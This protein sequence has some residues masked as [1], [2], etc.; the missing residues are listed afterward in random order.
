MRKNLKKYNKKT[1][2]LLV[3][4]SLL[5][6]F[7]FNDLAFSKDGKNLDNIEKTFENSILIDSS[8]YDS[9]TL[10]VHILD[11]HGDAEAQK[12]ISGIIDFYDKQKPIEKI[13]AEGAPLGKVSLNLFKGIDEKFKK[14]ILD[15]MLSEMQIG[16]CEYY[17]SYNNRD[18]LFGIE[19]NELYNKNLK[20]IQDMLALNR[21]NEGFLNSLSSKV[22][23][24]K[25][26][27]LS[28]SLLNIEKAIEENTSN[29]HSKIKSFFSKDPD[30]DETAYESF[31]TYLYLKEESGKI[32]YKSAIKE[33]SALNKYLST[34]LSYK[35]YMQASSLL[36]ESG[37]RASIGKA[38]TIIAANAPEAGKKF[39]EIMTALR[40][41]YISQNMNTYDVYMQRQALKK[42]IADKYASEEEKEILYLADMVESVKQIYSL[43]ITRNDLLDFINARKQLRGISSKYLDIAESNTLVYLAENK[44]TDLIYSINLQRDMVFFNAVKNTIE[45]Q[46]GKTAP[47]ARPEEISGIKDF[48]RVF[49]VVTGGFHLEFTDFLRKNK[50]SYLNI[51]PKLEKDADRKQYI[52]T[53]NLPGKL[54]SKNITFEYCAFAPPLLNAVNNNENAS[55]KGIIIKN[56]VKAWLSSAEEAGLSKED[57]YADIYNWL[58]ENGVGEDALKDIKELSFL[59]DMHRSG[60]AAAENFEKEEEPAAAGEDIVRQRQD[61]DSPDAAVSAQSAG[62]EI[63]AADNAAEDLIK[64]DTVTKNEAVLEKSESSEETSVF[65]KIKKKLGLDFQHWRF[66]SVAAANSVFKA[67]KSYREFADIVKNAKKVSA[68]EFEV[69][70]GETGFYI[71]G[72]DGFTISVDEAVDV[73]EKFAKKKKRT[74]IILRLDEN[75]GRD[76]DKILA[77]TLKRKNKFVIISNDK[78][79]VKSVDSSSYKNVETAYLMPSGLSAVEALELIKEMTSA[80]VFSIRV[81]KS[82]FDS[83]GAYLFS[84]YRGKYLNLYIQDGKVDE[85]YGDFIFEGRGKSLLISSEPAVH[86]QQKK[87]SLAAYRNIAATPVIQLVIGFEFFASFSM[88]YL[89]GKGY[90]LSFLSTMFAFCGILNIIGSLVSSYASKFFGKRNVLMVN[91]LLHCAGDALLLV[92]GWSPVLLGFALGVPAM[93][94]AGIATLLIPFLHSSLKAVGKED[95]FES[96]YGKTRSIFWIG[97]ALSSIFGSWLAQAV[98][99]AFVIAL[100]S[101]IITVFSVYSIITTGTIED[102]DKQEMTDEEK[103]FSH[104]KEGKKI[105]Q[106]IKTVFTTKGLN[107]T[108]IINFIVDSV[109]FVLLALGVQPML[110]ESGLSLSLLGLVA[111]SANIMQSVASKYANKIS[112]IVNSTLKRTLYFAS[113]TA[114]AAGFIVFNNPLLL[115]AFYILANFWQGASSIIEPAKVEEKLPDDITPY[116]F[117]AKTIINSALAAA[118]QLILAS[119]FKVFSVDIIL[120]AVIGVITVAS[121]VLGS[122]FKDGHKKDKGI[123]EVLSDTQYTRQLLSAA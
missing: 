81:D 30:F 117:S 14:D 113:L 11:S 45:N 61:G 35:D 73:V 24:L 108:V 74:E 18:I 49:V 79:F 104:L 107:T 86:L 54:G 83:V 3:S 34:V 122:V 13:F 28:K 62:A 10:I 6:S 121:V 29:S 118:V 32:N 106:G 21:E 20:L 85:Q 115:I 97:L 71:E 100:S 48:S 47:E 90:D 94:A 93:A 55:L 102:A 33:V 19:D 76:H 88:I 46:T 9:D 82:I 87:T 23:M 101:A 12:K 63:A 53:I 8:Y 84:K 92:A 58:T 1:V 44:I 16:A 68:L 66:P 43:S 15:K 37:D 67:A 36:A 65:A 4:V 64:N 42:Y 51:A 59:S 31:F 60:K 110:D 120:T 105:W 112:S 39:P 72:S 40:M 69:K 26:I 5:I 50:I 38:Y 99:Q 7:V 27:H 75:I 25:K 89:N 22:G 123:G 116:W 109:L 114:L 95:K 119:A 2:S 57:I 70:L 52:D 77:L 78:E 98:S 111:F 41:N 17:A 103:E 96:V 80:G 91:L 56:I